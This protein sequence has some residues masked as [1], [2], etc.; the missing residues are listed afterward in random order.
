MLTPKNMHALRTLFNIAHK[1]HPVLGSSWILVLENLNSLD[2]ILNSPRTTTQVR[3][4]FILATHPSKHLINLC[5]DAL[6]I[7]VSDSTSFE[8][9]SMNN[10][11]IATPSMDGHVRARKSSNCMQ[12]AASAS[13]MGGMPSDLAILSVAANQLFQSTEHMGTEA[14]VCILI[15]LRSVSNRALPTAFQLP[16]QSRCAVRLE[17]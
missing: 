17:T 8:K 5:T 6:L 4:T 16:S 1:L 11:V 12:D 3:N 14:V 9:L 13:S 7:G 2:R 15:G 10:N